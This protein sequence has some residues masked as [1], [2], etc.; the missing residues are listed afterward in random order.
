MES[1]MELSVET[2]GP[3]SHKFVSKTNEEME[4]P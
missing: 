3:T 4:T 2:K 1:L